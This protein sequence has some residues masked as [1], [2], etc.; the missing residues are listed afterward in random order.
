MIGLVTSCIVMQDE[1]GQTLEVGK[2]DIQSVTGQSNDLETRIG[3]PSL[4]D[5]V[6]SI[7][8]RQFYKTKKQKCQ[9]IM[10]SF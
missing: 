5:S 6:Q 1:Q 10:E 4:G 8:N 3:G 2:E 9:C 7:E